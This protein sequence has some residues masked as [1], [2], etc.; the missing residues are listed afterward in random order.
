LW[1]FSALWIRYTTQTAKKKCLDAL[2]ATLALLATDPSYNTNLALLKTGCQFVFSTSRLFNLLPFGGNTHFI[3]TQLARYLGAAARCGEPTCSHA[4]VLAFRSLLISTQTALMTERSTIN[5]IISIWQEVA[6]SVIV[7]EDLLLMTEA[8]VRLIV[9][10]P[11]S[12]GRESLSCLLGP[13]IASIHQGISAEHPEEIIVSN[14]LRILTTAVRF[15]DVPRD[16]DGNHISEEFIGVLFPVMHQTLLKLQGSEEIATRLFDLMSK[17][18]LNLKEMISSQ[19]QPLLQAVAVNFQSYRFAGALNAFS[20]AVEAFGSSNEQL[21]LYFSELFQFVGKEA[22]PFLHL[23]H[24]LV[25]CFFEMAFRF[26]LFAPSA[27]LGSPEDSV[28]PQVTEM[29][30]RAA[31]VN[32]NSS[33]RDAAKNAIVFVTQLV[34]RCDTLL[35]S[36][37]SKINMLV[38]SYLGLEVI[39]SSL[40]GLTKTVHPH[41]RPNLA[42]CFCAIILSCNENNLNQACFNWIELTTND[43]LREHFSTAES[44]KQ[45]ADCLYSLAHSS[46]ARFKAMALD[47]AKICNMEATPDVLVS[48]YFI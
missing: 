48:Y 45:I 24:E 8:V 10:L 4:A 47:I 44:R 19:T 1:K 32:M 17:L 14:H 37:K 28:V 7:I 16:P 18:F 39:K 43:C 22:L 38:A 36:Y 30:I 2:N 25:A 13:V 40:T 9:L 11:A 15:L 12:E 31:L 42:A 35:D 33:D 29:V 6:Q 46:T 27:L 20:A 26:M 3:G 5:A 23:S 21:Q 34:S 41:L